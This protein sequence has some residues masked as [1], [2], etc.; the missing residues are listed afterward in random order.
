MSKYNLNDKVALVTG[1]SRGIGRQ[2]ALTLAENGAMVIVNYCGSKEK[3][4]EVVELIKSNGGNAVAMQ[5]NVS[6][7]AGIPY[8]SVRNDKWYD[9]Y[10]SAEIQEENE[11]VYNEINLKND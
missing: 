7:Y 8:Y 3:A 11:Y 2:I 5:C 6:D 10:D 4:D 9:L 1:A